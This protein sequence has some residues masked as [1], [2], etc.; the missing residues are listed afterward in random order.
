MYRVKIPKVIFQTA[1]KS[2][3]NYVIEQIRHFSPGWEY[4]FFN[5]EDCLRFFDEN[6][7][8]EFLEVKEKFISFKRGEHKSDLFRYYYLYVHGG[9]YFD[10]DAMLATNIEEI[11]VDFQFF[12]VKS[13]YF[14]GTMFQGFIGCE[15]RN[16]IIYEALKDAYTVSQEA[17]DDYGHLLCKNLHDIIVR[18]NFKERT[19]M[20]GKIFHEAKHGDNCA[21][22]V[23]KKINNK[24]VLYHYYIHKIIPLLTPKRKIGI[25]IKSP[26]K[27]I[28]E[29]GCLQ[30]SL[31]LYETLKNNKNYKVDFLSGDVGYKKFNFTNIPIKT[32]GLNILDKFF[33]YDAIIFLSGNI[34]DVPILKK[35]YD[36][37]V[38]MI[39]YN[40]GNVY[41]IYQEDII[42]NKHHFIK[43]NTKDIFK[44]ISDY[45]TIPNYGKNVDFFEAIFN[46]PSKVV[47]YT[48]NTTIC[49]AYVTMLGK[50]ESHDGVDDNILKWSQIKC[51]E[52]TAI[53]IAEPN[54]NLT[55]TC[56]IP[57]LIC[58]KLYERGH[59]N[60]KVV[61]LGKLDEK[62]HT[63]YS[64]FLNSLEIHRQNLIE[65]YPRMILMDVCKILGEKR[66]NVVPLSYHY[67]NPLNFLHLEMLYMNYPLVHNSTPFKDGGYFYQTIDEGVD[68][69]EEAMVQK[70]ANEK[71][72]SNISKINKKI[73]WKYNPQNVT[74]LNK[75]ILMIEDVIKEKRKWH[76]ILSNKTASSFD[77]TIFQNIFMK[78]LCH[79]MRAKGYLVKIQYIPDL[80]AIVEDKEKINASVEKEDFDE[81]R[82]Y[83]MIGCFDEKEMER[84]ELCENRMKFSSLWITYGKKINRNKSLLEK[85]SEEG[86]KHLHFEKMVNYNDIFQALGN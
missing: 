40:C 22:V 63:S 86:K 84:K 16:E 74:V 49:D 54:V 36:N 33:D 72:L 59:R 85:F 57:L 3:P 17:L 50:K 77:P 70:I 61:L 80:K 66:Y 37:N 47:P 30:Q 34:V 15:P 45:W 58:E 12:T 46:T 32:I 20:K 27:S 48:W 29:N 53:L 52:Q 26:Q 8:Q 14:P 79:K 24:I 2:P 25:L 71:A 18:G 11:I 69:L 44:Y 62:T 38:K 31:F 5:D 83:I 65:F 43:D 81:K 42:F 6:P 41:Y 64:K 13:T 35:F 28:F 75:H 73:L 68:K 39:R 4:K 23:D 56:M 1:K 9:V 7:L 21:K 78:D 60:F 10:T 19:D 51:G 82:E 55:K 76:V 67:D